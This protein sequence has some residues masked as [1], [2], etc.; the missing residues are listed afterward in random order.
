MSYGEKSLAL[1]SSFHW[2]RVL[3]RRRPEAAALPEDRLKPELGLR[4]GTLRSTMGP[5]ICFLTEDMG[6]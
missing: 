4:E 1:I 3:G 2:S 5:D 6:H